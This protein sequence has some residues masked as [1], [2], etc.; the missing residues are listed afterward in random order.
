MLWPPMAEDFVQMDAEGRM[1][2]VQGVGMDAVACGNSQEMVGRNFA[3]DQDE[4]YRR[5]YWWYYCCLFD[6]HWCWDCFFSVPV[7]FAFAVVLLRH[8]QIPISV[9]VP[10]RMLVFVDL[11]I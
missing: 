10:P 1:D 5:C 4:C 6:I 3:A 2:Q 7:R 11:M 8:E 9:G